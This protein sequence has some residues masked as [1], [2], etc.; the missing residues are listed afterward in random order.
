MNI[1]QRLINK[2]AYGIFYF[3][4]LEEDDYAFDYTWIVLTSYA[5]HYTVTFGQVL[6]MHKMGVDRW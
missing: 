2:M 5:K 4:L 6:N 1:I 3:P